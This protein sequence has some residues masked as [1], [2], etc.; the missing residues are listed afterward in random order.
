M[1]DKKC[2]L[3][4]IIF[5]ELSSHSDFYVTVLPLFIYSIS[6]YLKIGNDKNRVKLCGCLN[7]EAVNEIDICL[8]VTFLNQCL[9]NILG[10]MAFDE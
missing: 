6:S 4:A 1:F 5:D 3:Y 2:Y 7:S 8:N 9:L 10:K